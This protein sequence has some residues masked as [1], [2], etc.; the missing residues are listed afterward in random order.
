MIQIW[1]VPSEC[2]P[3]NLV[4]LVIDYQHY[5]ISESNQLEQSMAYFDVIPPDKLNIEAYEVLFKALAREGMLE[6]LQRFWSNLKKSAIKPSLK[7]YIAA[8]QCLGHQKTL[9]Q[10]QQNQGN[11]LRGI[12]KKNS[13]REAVSFFLPMF[14]SQ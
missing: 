7:C 11:L 5:L 2:G 6:D 3:S 4:V 10:S 9:D 14:S 12:D 1:Q 8:F 13:R